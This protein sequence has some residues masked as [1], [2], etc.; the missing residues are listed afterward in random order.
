MGWPVRSLNEAL[1]IISSQETQTTT[2]YAAVLRCE[3]LFRIPCTLGTV[4]RD[5]GPRSR[6]GCNYQL[7]TF[8]SSQTGKKIENA[9]DGVFHLPPMNL[10]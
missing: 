3:K 6:L 1:K 10:D 4:M 8:R 9:W 5:K 7:V 2:M